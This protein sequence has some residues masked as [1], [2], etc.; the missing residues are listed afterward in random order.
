MTHIN[1]YQFNHLPATG[2]VGA[3]VGSK[4]GLGV[5]LIAK[6]HKINIQFFLS[7]FFL[8]HTKTNFKTKQNA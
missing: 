2:Y 8:Q 5:T 4:V 6:V 7:V 3:N 1:L